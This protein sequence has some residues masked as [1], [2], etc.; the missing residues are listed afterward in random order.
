MYHACDTKG[1]KGRQGRLRQ[2]PFFIYWLLAKINN[3]WTRNN[4]GNSLKGNAVLK[5]SWHET[6][7]YKLDKLSEFPELSQYFEHKDSSKTYLYKIFCRY[8]KRAVV[9]R[10]ILEKT[11]IASELNTIKLI[12]RSGFLK[13]IQGDNKALVTAIKSYLDLRDDILD[14]IKSETSVFPHKMHHNI[15]RFRKINRK[16]FDKI[17]NELT[18]EGKILKNIPD[19]TL[20]LN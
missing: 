8:Q 4:F 13:E 18:D 7:T 17:I 20:Y 5:E 14:Y 15:R 1:K 11:K 2:Y 9:E 10:I 12:G 16:F 6:I 19:K 3:L